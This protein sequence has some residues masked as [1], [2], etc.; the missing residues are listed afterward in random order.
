MIRGLGISAG[1][2]TSLARAQEILANNLANAGTTGFRQDR[3][4]FHLSA[5]TQAGGAAAA[6]GGVQSVPSLSDKLDLAPGSFET[7]E[8]PLHISVSGPG[9]LVVQGPD[10]EMYTRDGSLVRSDD[11]TILHRSGHPILLEG[12]TLTAPPSARLTFGSDGTVLVDGSPQ[13]KL[14]LV[15]LSDATQI[16]HA[17]AGLLSTTQEAEPD[18]TSRIVQGSLEGA[19]VDPVL[20]MVQMTELLHDFEADQRAILTQDSSLGKLIQWASG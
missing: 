19:N 10:G 20:S 16:K 15:A 7:T 11:G 9:F 17:G 12:G 1:A 4:T 13:G 2:L 5:G 8:S 18:T 3:F 6:A 14:R